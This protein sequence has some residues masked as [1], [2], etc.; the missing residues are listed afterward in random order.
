MEQILRDLRLSGRVMAR[1]PGVTA[2]AHNSVASERWVDAWLYVRHAAKREFPAAG[3]L[4]AD[5]LRK[6]D[7]RSTIQWGDTRARRLLG[8]AFAQ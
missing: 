3:S 4:D 1:K 8:P 6:V 2:L 5:Y 7:R